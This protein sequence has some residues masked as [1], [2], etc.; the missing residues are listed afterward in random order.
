ME[1]FINN[2][3]LQHIAEKILFNLNYNN[4]RVCEHINQ[5]MQQILNDLFFWLRKLIQKGLSPKNQE[6][7]KTA[8]DLTKN[9]ELE[10]F[11]LS[12]LKKSSKNEKVVDLHC[13]IDEDFITKSGEKIKESMKIENSNAPDVNGMTPIHRAVQNG[14]T[15]IVKILATLTDNS[16]A[17]DI[18]GRTPIH[19]AA[20]WGNAEIVKVLASLTDN[21]N[22][23]DDYGMTP[24]NW[25]T[26]REHTEIVKI[27]APLT[28]NPN[29]PDDYGMTPI[30]MATH[31]GHTEIVNI[32]ATF[33][34]NT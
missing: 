8:I 20:Y 24:I 26:Y 30:E 9:S 13:Y 1:N 4:L 27:L 25:A 10:K 15:E 23:P 16:N 11:V 21:P 2:P 32:L 34:K 31:N 7:W 14:N 3:G 12:Y 6:D 33:D 18:Y 5:T 29:A 17:P 19:Y 22:A 28:D